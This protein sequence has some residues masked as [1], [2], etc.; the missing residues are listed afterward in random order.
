MKEIHVKRDK[1][2]NIKYTKTHS[3]LEVP[4]QVKL[5]LGIVIDN[6]D[7][8]LLNVTGVFSFEFVAQFF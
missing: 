2:V 5:P 4:V 7:Q 3:M 1:N 6:P 8:C